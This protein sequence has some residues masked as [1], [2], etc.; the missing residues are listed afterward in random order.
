MISESAVTLTGGRDGNR[1]SVSTKAQRDVTRPTLLAPM[2][3]GTGND[4][5][6]TYMRLDSSIHL[7]APLI[8]TRARRRLHVSS[9]ASF[10]SSFCWP[11]FFNRRRHSGAA[12]PPDPEVREWC[13]AHVHVGAVCSRQERTWCCL[14]LCLACPSAVAPLGQICPCP[15]PPRLHHPQCLL[16]VNVSVLKLF[17]FVYLLNHLFLRTCQLP[18]PHPLELPLQPSPSPHSSRPW[19][20]A[21]A[22]NSAFLLDN[23]SLV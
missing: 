8:P 10:L 23:T 13:R 1:V 17:I 7:Y 5:L 20:H 2:A 22:C 6:G 11:V 3:T 15:L 14:S 18:T 12:E 19:L 21:T 9:G 16:L 4:C